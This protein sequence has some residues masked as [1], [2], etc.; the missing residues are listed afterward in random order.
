MLVGINTSAHSTFFT[1]TTSSSSRHTKITMYRE[2]LNYE[3]NLKAHSDLAHS[4][5]IKSPAD[6]RARWMTMRE[7][8]SLANENMISASPFQ[9]DCIRS[10]YRHCNLESEGISRAR[11]KAG[12]LFYLQQNRD[13][14]GQD[15][16]YFQHIDAFLFTV[17]FKSQV[18]N[19]ATLHSFLI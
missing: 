8:T 11:D 10:H 16:L 5:A 1:Q 17:G 19:A 3:R 18:K 13:S 15:L 7:V 6:W 2:F 9:N 14:W 12:L 4:P